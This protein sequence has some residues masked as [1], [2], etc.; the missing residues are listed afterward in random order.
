MPPRNKP[1][2]SS[3][4]SKKPT[5]KA[6]PS[7]PSKFGI[8][9]FFD[10]HLATS[11]NPKSSNHSLPAS[12]TPPDPGSTGPVQRDPVDTKRSDDDKQLP[13]MVQGGE[14]VE[15]IEDG[16]NPAEEGTENGAGSGDAGEFD[17][18]I[19]PEGSKWVLRKRV[20]FSPGMLI[21]QS[22]DDG[23]DD[24]TWKI[25]P[26][27]DRLQS[28]SKQAPEL[29]KCLA[30]GSDFSLNLRKC[31]SNM[32][33]PASESNPEE[34]PHS[35]PFKVPRKSS[36]LSNGEGLKKIK[37]HQDA[38]ID[39]QEVTVSDVNNLA[40]SC[41]SPFRTPPSLSF[42]SSKSARSVVQN[43]NVLESLGLRQHRKALLDLLDQ[44]NDVISVEDS[45]LTAESLSTR[46]D[47]CEKCGE[48][49][50]PVN[51]LTRNR[52]EDNNLAAS[53]PCF[54]VLEVTEK[55]E[56]ANLPKAQ[57]TLKALRL[58]DEQS[59]TERYVHLRDEWFYSV[60]EPG[61]TV[62]VLGEFDGS[63]KCDV[64][65]EQNL[66]ILQPNI[67][68]SG[69]RV[70]GSFSCARRAVLD[71]RLKCNE[72]SSVALMGS[73]LHQVFQAGLS[74][75]DPTADQ[76][77][78]YSRTVINKNFENLYACE[79]NENDIYKSLIAAIPRM[80]KWINVF[81]HSQ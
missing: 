61:D 80:L 73:L 52:L 51:K 12:T 23:G 66:L 20:K 72:Y 46:Q 35:P 40:L 54:L 3:S 18:K 10:R 14:M 48:A 60:V 22:Q 69:T 19:S 6:K 32:V 1:A 34:L 65:H 81:K 55:Y 8:Q 74:V 59:G 30:D 2:A 16:K 56:P 78:E 37:E 44:V 27:N 7:Q 39:A 26:V 67:M 13:E 62:H 64:S 75:C 33:S 38:N 58:L 31:S 42:S 28:I 77:Q 29:I 63:G 76:L 17:E 43:Y 21:K 53:C 41:Q 70:A 11:Q 49:S 4:S 68:V 9:H 25:S 47:H 45:A 36:L 79:V 24:I 50:V 71:E 57:C 5:P 15:M